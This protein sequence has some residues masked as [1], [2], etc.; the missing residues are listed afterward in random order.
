MTSIS[1]KMVPLRRV[2]SGAII[3]THE[4]IGK[5]EQM[6]SHWA[7]RGLKKLARET[8]H[9][10]RRN[11]TLFVN[12]STNTATLPPDW[13]E[14]IFIGVIVNGRKVPLRHR[15]D[16]V[17]EKFIEDIPC[18]D[19]CPKCKQDKAICNELTIT[20]DISTV[21]IE[22]E[23]YEQSVIKK[24]SPD[25]SYYLE[26][27]IPVWDIP[28]Q[29][30]IYTTSKQYVAS[31]ELKPCGCID[32]TPENIETIRCCCPEVYNAYYAPCDSSCSEEY[33]G[34]KIF[35][36]N[37]IIQFDKIGKFSK[38]YV[39][40]RGFLAKRGGQY[41]VPE[42]AV[43]ALIAWVKY[44]SIQNRKNIPDRVIDR[45]FEDY[46]R[47]RGNLSK[48]LG[49]I[50]LSMIIQA[51]SSTPKFDIDTF[52][53]EPVSCERP[54][55]VVTST[56]DAEGNCSTSTTTAPCP[57]SSTSAKV[58]NPFSIAAICG[59]GDG[60]ADGTNTYQDDKLIG[61]I[62]VV[63]IVV[64]N[65]NETIKGGS[66]TIDTVT[67]TISR[68]QGDGITPNNWSDGDVLVVPTFFKLIYAAINS[69][70]TPQTISIKSG[71][72]GGP[73]AGTNVYQ[74]DKLK[75]SFGIEFII[76]NNNNETSADQEFTIDTVNGI[77][78]RWQGDNTTPSNWA[79][80]DELIIPAFF[81]TS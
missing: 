67:G 30:V 56:T 32:E 11:V 74:N 4:D 70:T 53:Y 36:E 39:E 19:V 37:G 72:V 41:Y 1:K 54:V 2:V 60:P 7:A 76:V 17:S 14:E 21:I 28:S 50:S 45:W 42:V 68:W 66:F 64:N 47:E 57:P 59:I 6:Y 10:N 20:E 13:D 49:R 16:L 62:G 27:R 61:A 24:L 40:Y 75:N 63:M 26:T 81:K 25:G 31:I 58:Y 22:G 12:R 43:E 5:V 35:E 71:D 48:I 51:V 78:S 44:K 34:Y 52:V 46:R 38:V 18:E 3:D 33:G 15:T 65:S 29:S 73:V 79:S 69:S 23:N 9:G 55:L 80:G 8:L 77:L